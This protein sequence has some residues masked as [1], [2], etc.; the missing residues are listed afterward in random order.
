MPL[1]MLLFAI[2]ERHLMLY[3]RLEILFGIIYGI[4]AIGEKNHWG[5][6]KDSGASN[7]ATWTALAAY[8]YIVVRGLDNRKKAMIKEIE[9]NEIEEEAKNKTECARHKAEM[10]KLMERLKQESRQKVNTQAQKASI[11]G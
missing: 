2:R 11:S 3:A 7:L 4:Y 9:A 10:E 1:G 8:L 5:T 6:L